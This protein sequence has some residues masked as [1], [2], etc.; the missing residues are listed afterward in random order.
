MERHGTSAS[1]VGQRTRF[2]LNRSG[3]RQVNAALHRIAITQWRGVGDKGHAYV[4]RRMAAGATKTEA[5]RLLRRRLS[6][7]I[8]GRLLL[9]E[10]RRAERARRRR[11][12]CRRLT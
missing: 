8:F 11:I 4:E 12:F 7:E 9:D 2:R 6:D 3:N 1:V 5:L 10:R